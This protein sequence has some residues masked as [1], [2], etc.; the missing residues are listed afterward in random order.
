MTIDPSSAG[1]DERPGLGKGIKSEAEI[2]GEPST[3]EEFHVN[4]A[5][6]E[7]FKHDDSMFVIAA[8]EDKDGHRSSLVSNGDCPIN[9]GTLAPVTVREG[10]STNYLLPR[11]VIGVENNSIPVTNIILQIRPHPGGSHEASV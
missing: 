8:A 5:R 6:A 2:P 4:S 1:Q 11:Y 10:N 9:M 7:G 3:V